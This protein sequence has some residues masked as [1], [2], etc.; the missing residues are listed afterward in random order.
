MPRFLHPAR[1]RHLRRIHDAK[2]DRGQPRHPTLIQK[3]A[4]IWAG[5]TFGSTKVK[6]DQSSQSYCQGGHESGGNQSGHWNNAS[7]TYWS[8]SVCILSQRKIREVE[9]L[10]HI[11]L[12]R[13]PNYL[14]PCMPLTFSVWCIRHSNWVLNSLVHPHTHTR[15]HTSTHTHTLSDAHT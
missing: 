8:K 9:N 12:C 10:L 5:S 2:N 13:S 14:L 11:H 1:L 6:S 4:S 15:M 7:S 3:G